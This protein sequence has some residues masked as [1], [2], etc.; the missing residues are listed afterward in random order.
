VDAPCG[1]R[2]PA[3]SRLGSEGSNPVELYARGRIERKAR[4]SPVL[5]QVTGYA[6]LLQFGNS[7]TRT[8]CSGASHCQQKCIEYM[9]TI[10]LQRVA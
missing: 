9:Y 3:R 10:H 7:V 5:K 1:G 8:Q 4:A 2:R 6:R